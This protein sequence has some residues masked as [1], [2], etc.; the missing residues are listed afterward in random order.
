M[1]AIQQGRWYVKCD[2]CPIR[3]DLAPGAMPRDMLRMPSGWL[4]LGGDRH[5]CLQC[6]PKALS[7]QL[8][9][10]AGWK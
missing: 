8:G 3:I 5:V 10:S 1:L 4:G 7:G 2:G 6:Q 9:A